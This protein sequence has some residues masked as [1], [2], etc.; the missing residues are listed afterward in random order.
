[1]LRIATLL[2]VLVIAA[3]PAFAEAQQR[4]RVGQP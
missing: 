1:M 4:L 3:P 2:A